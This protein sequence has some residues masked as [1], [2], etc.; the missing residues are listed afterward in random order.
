MLVLQIEGPRAGQVE[1]M[2][3]WVALEL[4][5]QGRVKRIHGLDA[6]G[7]PIID[8]PAPPP[9]VAAA[10]APVPTKAPAP[11]LPGRRARRTS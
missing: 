10:T 1:Y 5:R 3:P 9:E 7:N 8:G 11:P 2:V 4:I 6:D